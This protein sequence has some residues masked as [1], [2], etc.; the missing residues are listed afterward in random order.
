MSAEN[1]P[2]P[3]EELKMRI[4]ALL[5]GELPSEE[6]TALQAQIAADPELTALHARL[7]KAMELLHEATALPEQP[8][9]ETPARLSSERRERLLAHF[10]TPAPPSTSPVTTM[11]IAAKPRREWVWMVQLGLAA[12]VVVFVGVGLLTSGSSPKLVATA[13]FSPP[14]AWHEKDVSDREP[15]FSLNSTHFSVTGSIQIAP[16][17]RGVNGK[18]FDT[19]VDG[20]SAGST[21]SSTP[22]ALMKSGMGNFELTPSSPGIIPPPPPPPIS[23]NPATFSQGTL[24][25]NPRALS[26]NSGTMLGNSTRY[27]LEDITE[28]KKRD[29]AKVAFATDVN[30][31]SNV[32]VSNGGT[33]TV[34]GSNTYTGV[35][36]ISGSVLT[37]NADSVNTFGGVSSSGTVSAGGTVSTMNTANA[38]FYDR[39]T[40]GNGIVTLGSANVGALSDNNFAYGTMSGTIASNQPVS[41]TSSV[42]MSVPSPVLTRDIEVTAGKPLTV[43]GTFDHA[44]QDRNKEQAIQPEAL[45]VTSGGLAGQGAGSGGGTKAE[46]K[47]LPMVGG[48]F[49]YLDSATSAPSAGSGGNVFYSGGTVGRAVAGEPVRTPE[50][51]KMED[52]SRRMT[53]A[54]KSAGTGGA[55]DSKP[56][57]APQAK[58]NVEQVK[59]LSVEAQGLYDS[60]RP[61]LAKKRAEQ[62]LNVDPTNTAARRLEEKVDRT[63]SDYG[64]AAYNE[65]RADAIA[66]TDM[67]WARP[68]RRFDSPIEIASPQ[69]NTERIRKKL[70]RIIIP[71]LELRNA[72]LAE[73]ID[74][75]KKKSVEM[76][77][78]SPPGERGTNIVL[79]LAGDGS[80]GAAAPTATP[81]GDPKDARITV[82]LTN[83]PLS[84]ALKY[85]TGLANLKY[86][87]EPY[88]ISIVP[89]V[90]CTDV[91][92]TKEWTIPADLIP[93]PLG[94]DPDGKID[95]KLAKDWLIANGLTFNGNTSAI[96]IS[97]SNRLIVRNTQDQLDLVDTILEVSKKDRADKAAQVAA[98]SAPIPQP[99]IPTSQNAFSTFSLNVSDVS[100]QLAAASIEHGHM[101]DPASIRSEEFINAFD[102]RDPEPAPGAPLAFATERARYPFAQNRDLLRFSVKTAAA[103]R[104][105]GRPLNIVLLLDKSGSM[106]RADRVDIVREALRV[107]ATQLQ[108]QDKLSIVTFARTPHLWANGV[109]GDKVNDVIARVNEITPEGGTN[110]EAALDLGYETAHRY[111]AVGSINRVVLFTDGAAN[112]GDVKPEALTK[113]VEAQRKQG[114]A[115]DCFGIGWEG[116]NDDLLEQLTRNADGRYGFINTPEDAAANFATQLAGAL[117]VAASDVKVQVEFN[118]RRVKAYRQIGYATHQ[119]TKEQFRDN[120]V[121]AAQI[122]AA[123]SGNALYV[124]EVDPHGEGDLGT[125]HVRFRV[126]GTSDYREHEWPVPFTGE[127]PPLEKASSALRLAG[128]A[129]AF[130]EMLATSPYA[131]EVTSDRLLNILQGVPSIYGTDPR[132][133]KLETLINQARSISGR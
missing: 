20:Y 61:D 113:K 23:G 1:Q 66:K 22:V 57:T 100:Y 102:Y 56:S 109:A 93:P 79:K 72:T 47:S 25:M 83:I 124:V 8:L 114:I 76:D 130:S 78:S 43:T 86:K 81:M 52:A 45:N 126:P 3:R 24:T 59:Q 80:T 48:T 29:E 62:I 37:A 73:A 51:K 19:V 128:A 132:P 101:P 7:G 6:A 71:K 11:P 5:M 95:R 92:I 70:D 115:L 30:G 120:S 118:P 84:E 65:T 10:K 64:V 33:L 67:A 14:A 85:V 107:L 119:L 122:G 69:A 90:E 77:D 63:L 104:Q 49:N 41:V 50:E 40:S 87:V 105:P 106:E 26:P 4:T 91:L 117:Q 28:L 108:P 44:D 53:M 38:D 94:A 35:P 97:K 123:E 18:G 32:L 110:L 27:F 96:F 58:T 131:T 75:L 89:V 46:S 54:S 2:T 111:F 99:E 15:A 121:N 34:T 39:A 82:S 13:D 31:A 60:G 68:I 112:L 98:V 74:F 103:G 12:A 116:Y 127:G 88:A 21:I 125:V 17:Q 36:V 42:N 133:K 129:S 16:Q 55:P 9:S